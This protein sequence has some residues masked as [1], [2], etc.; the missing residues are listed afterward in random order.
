MDMFSVKRKYSYIALYRIRLG[1]F[2]FIYLAFWT[3]SQIPL[4]IYIYIKTTFTCLSLE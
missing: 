1:A 2:I 3:V 4:N